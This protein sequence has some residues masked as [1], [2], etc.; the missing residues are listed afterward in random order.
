MHVHDGSIFFDYIWNMEHYYF[1]SIYGL[2]RCPTT[3]WL[4]GAVFRRQELLQPVTLLH[5]ALKQEL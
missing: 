2:R 5:A 1:L 3:H 4:Q